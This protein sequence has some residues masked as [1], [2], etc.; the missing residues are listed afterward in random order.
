MLS[1]HDNR[2]AFR[3]VSTR[4][5]ISPGEQCAGL[6]EACF[7]SVGEWSAAAAHAD[8]ALPF[9]WDA[10]L[11]WQGQS[12]QSLFRGTHCFVP[13]CQLRSCLY[14]D[15]MG[16]GQILQIDANK[17]DCNVCDWGVQRQFSM[18]FCAIKLT[19]QSMNRMKRSSESAQNTKKQ[20]WFLAALVPIN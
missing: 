18:G 14:A 6:R 4:E 8:W 13:C 3:P 16:L 9:W 19:E 7:W 1:R 17:G 2:A 15:S 11:L 10:V 5:Q 12:R 20:V